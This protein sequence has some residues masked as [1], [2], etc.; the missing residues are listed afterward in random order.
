L[1]KVKSGDKIE[2]EFQTPDKV[3]ASLEL[4]AE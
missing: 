4:Y 2:W 1:R 3:L